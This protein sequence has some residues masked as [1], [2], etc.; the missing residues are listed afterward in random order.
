MEKSQL[1]ELLSS[2]KSKTK[3]QRVT[4]GRRNKK[5]GAKHRSRGRLV[6]CPSVLAAAAAAP[7]AG[8]GIVFVHVYAPE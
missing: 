3:E 5:R 6:I 2:K 1:G 7:V 8:G 4:R